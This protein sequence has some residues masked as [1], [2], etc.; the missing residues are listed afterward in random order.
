M[1]SETFI[2]IY[3]QELESVIKRMSRDDTDRVIKLLYEA[4]REGRQVFLA[5]NGGSASTATHFACDLAKFTSVEGKSRFRAMA[6][7]DN[8]PLV[9]ALTNDLGWENVYVEQLKNLMRNGDVL[10]VISVHG[11]SGADKAGA[12]S[13]NLLKAAKFVKDNGGKVVGLAG[14]DGG[15]LK[16]IADACIVVPVNSTPHVEGFHLVL[17]HLICARLRELIAE[18]GVSA[19]VPAGILQSEST[20]SS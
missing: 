14:F 9:S 19:H 1:D 7:T 11:G 20:G 17:T 8:T 18:G 5:G 4:W 13:Q 12:W 16:Q 10:V 15:V 3:L 2:N 6:L